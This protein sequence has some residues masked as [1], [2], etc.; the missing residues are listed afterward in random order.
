MEHVSKTE[1]ILY[2]VYFDAELTDLSQVY[3]CKVIAFSL[4]EA[5]AKAKIA[6]PDSGRVRS[7]NTERD[8]M[9]KGPKREWFVW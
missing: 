2:N 9:E 1:A 3:C 5:I 6:F 4:E 8:F 7:A